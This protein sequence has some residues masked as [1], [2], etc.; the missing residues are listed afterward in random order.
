MVTLK[1]LLKEAK[2]KTERAKELRQEVI[3]E[4][5]KDEE[6]E[7]GLWVHTPFKEKGLTN[8]NMRKAYVK[9]QM[10]LLYPSFYLSKKAELDSI[11]ADLKRIYK[12]IEVMMFYDVDEIEFEQKKDSKEDKE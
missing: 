5:I 7:A 6:N 12:T 9:Q 8:D 3:K 4:K 10:L 2:D 11:E 1:S